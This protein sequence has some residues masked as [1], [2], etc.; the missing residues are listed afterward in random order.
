MPVRSTTA[1]WVMA[2]LPCP[3]PRWMHPVLACCLLA[4]LLSQGLANDVRSPPVDP[5]QAQVARWIQQLG[6][7]QYVE[8]KQAEAQLTRLGAAAFDALQQALKNPDLEIATRAKYILTHVQI[9]WERASDPPEV[10]QLLDGYGALPAAE[11]RQR[12]EQLAILAQAQGLPALCRIACYDVSPKLARQAALAVF[13]RDSLRAALRPATINSALGSAENVPVRWLR[14]LAD[15][16]LGARVDA[17]WLP[18]LDAELALVAQDSRDTEVSIVLGLLQYVL[19]LGLEAEDPQ[20]QFELLR[21]WTDLADPS[22]PVQQAMLSQLDDWME[23]LLYELQELGGTQQLALARSTQW[24]L[25]HQQWET[26]GLLERHYEQ[27]FRSDRLLLYLAAIAQGQQGRAAEAANLAA[28]A[29]QVKLPALELHNAYASILGEFGRHDWAEQEWRWVVDQAST[30]SPVSWNARRWLAQLRLHDRG[31]DQLA[32]DLLQEVL[33]A[34][35][36]LPV[37]KHQ[38]LVRGSTGL[39]LRELESQRAFYVACVQAAAGDVA[40]Q[41]KSLNQAYRLNSEDPDVLIAM[42]QISAGDAPYRQQVRGRIRRICEQLEFAIEKNPHEANNYN[43]WAWLVSNT[44]GDYQQA[45][46]YSLRSL[47]LQ[48]G[49]ASYLDTLGRCYYAVGDLENAVRY[50]QQAVQKHPHLS[51]MQRQL[52]LFE[53]ELAAAK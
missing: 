13:T 25:Q 20:T 3:G 42:Y 34:V 53:Q 35:E 22:G 49:S 28:R 19:Q 26:L 51:V 2:W 4:Q 40:G 43:H 21:R 23:L 30:L 24:T 9:E 29:Q 48:Q 11:R 45:L 6:S 15:Q 17:R 1:R 47:E 44:E 39:L 33:A 46:A 41:R 14:T 12:M 5:P 31:E 38:R 16:R 18:L 32:A 7:D 50:Q 8:R 52:K 10:R 36:A 27:T 37:E